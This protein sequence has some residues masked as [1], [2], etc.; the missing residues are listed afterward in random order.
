MLY[1]TMKKVVFILGPITSLKRIVFPGG[2]LSTVG[3]EQWMREKLDLSLAGPQKTLGQL[4]SRQEAQDHRH[5]SFKDPKCSLKQAG[6][7]SNIPSP[8]YSVPNPTSQVPS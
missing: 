8:T 6:K 2:G 1:T 4:N 5:F 7:P 3:W